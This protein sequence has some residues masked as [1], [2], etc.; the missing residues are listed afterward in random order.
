G[1]RV[2]KMAD[3]EAAFENAKLATKPV[4]ID[5]SVD[6]AAAPLPGKIVMDEAL[7]YTKFEIQ[8]VLEDHRFAK[9]PPLK[10]ILRRF[11]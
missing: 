5:V 1:F 3:L 4:I 10:T 11:L 2:E 6:S 7:G 8:S 9:M